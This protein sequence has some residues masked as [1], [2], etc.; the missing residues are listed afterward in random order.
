M[1][2]PLDCMPAPA[3]KWRGV[4][5]DR[6]AGI[7]V[8][9]ISKRSLEMKAQH[10]ISGKWVKKGGEFV[11]VAVARDEKGKPIARVVFHSYSSH[12]P[13]P[14]SLFNKVI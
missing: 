4:K 5:S 9:L 6:L 13:A 3:G 10:D 1:G 7:E 14:T 2:F 11:F 12:A 8:E